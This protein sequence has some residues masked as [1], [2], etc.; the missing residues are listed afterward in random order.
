MHLRFLLM[1]LGGKMVRRSL[2]RILIAAVII[3]LLTLASQF[4]IVQIGAFTIGYHG[5]DVIRSLVM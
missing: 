5:Y 1:H 4:D 3:D 2:K